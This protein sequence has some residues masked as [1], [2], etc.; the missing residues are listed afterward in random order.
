MNIS[1]RSQMTA[2]VAA[3]SA[4]VV[5]V[6][7]I[8]QPD[9]LPSAERIAAAIQL[10]AFSNPVIAITDNIFFA[11]G[12]FLDQDFV[13]DNI[14]WPDT[15]VGEFLYA[16]LNVGI[17]PDLANQFSTGPLSGLIN[18]LGGYGFAGVTTALVL[19][20][21]VARSVFN[22][23]FAVV[24]AV[25]ELIAGDPEAALQAL[26]TGI[27]EPLQ[28]AVEQA[29]IDV[30]YIVDNIIE[31][32]QIGFIT[33]PRLVA[34]V[35]GAA[36]ANVSLILE[37]LADTA[38]S[39]VANLAALNIEGAW[40]D[41]VDGILGPDGTL[42]QIV[43]LTVG[44]GLGEFVNEDDF[45][46]T[47]PSIRSVLTSELQRLG[48]EKFLGDGGITND[49][50]FGFADATAAVTEPAPVA[51][52]QVSAPAVALESAPAV[53]EAPAV[54]EAVVEAPAVPKAVVEA[55]APVS[56]PAATTEV[57]DVAAP[58]VRESVRASAAPRASAR[59]SRVG[60]DSA[61]STGTSAETD[62]ST[63]AGTPDSAGP[64]GATAGDSGSVNESSAPKKSSPRGSKKAAAAASS[65]G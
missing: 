24:A 45:V 29:A 38:A 21:G 65:A 49:P 32:I 55:P 40:N 37:S 43:E 58:A 50:L 22:A 7:P 35:V 57:A 18:N 4:A 56:E 14:V 63:G 1:L 13:S 44:L 15:F 47:N 5:A 53:V 16:P 42:G 9:L 25:E 33:L 30:G 46:M 2:G 26:R 36:V 8:T 20:D 23:P 61:V 11:T 12:Y 52:V 64:T 41:V 6:A 51:A 28:L 59:K 39:F 34:G 60:D 31:N 48:S 27:I 10:S 17:I 19:V 62:T 3:L 54:P